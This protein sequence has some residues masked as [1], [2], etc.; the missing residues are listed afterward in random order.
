[1]ATLKES[2][3]AFL[4]RGS[5]RKA[6]TYTASQTKAA[7]ISK[8]SGGYS[9]NPPSAEDMISKAIPDLSGSNFPAA[10]PRKRPFRK[11]RAV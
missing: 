11:P 10:A 6:G 8:A 9:Q 4:K 1:M 2:V 3:S 5:K 7:Q